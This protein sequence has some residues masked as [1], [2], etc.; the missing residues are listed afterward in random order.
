[1]HGM[2]KFIVAV[3]AMAL[4]SIAVASHSNLQVPPSD[5]FVLGGEQRTVMK[6]SGKNV[7]QTNVVILSRAGTEET[8]IANVAPGETFAHDYAVGQAALIRN[9]SSTETA[10]LSVDFT[11]SPSSL[12]MRYTLPQKR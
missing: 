2:A 1:M 10:R 9:Q 11:G 7:G 3:A 12:S 5:T 8:V 6:V 4:P